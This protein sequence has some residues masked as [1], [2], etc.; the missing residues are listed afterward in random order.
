MKLFHPT[1]NPNSFCCRCANGETV[2]EGTINC[3]EGGTS[4][5]F[6][7]TWEALL[8]VMELSTLEDW[9]AY[10]YH[11]IDAQ[12]YPLPPVRDAYPVNGAPHALTTETSCESTHCGLA[13]GDR[14]GPWTINKSQASAAC[15]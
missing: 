12:P 8:T 15:V 4:A 11:G 6:D 5:N 1:K 9:P 10:M 2:I 14:N 13:Q 7:N 3:M